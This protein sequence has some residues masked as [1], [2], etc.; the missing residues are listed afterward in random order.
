MLI[1]DYYRSEPDQTW[2]IGR[3][4]GIRHGVIRLPEDPEFDPADRSHWLTVDRRF[5]EY[6]IQPIVVEP[7]PNCLHDHIKAGD[8]RRDE[9]I[10]K[11]IRMFSIM[12]ELEIRTI[13]FNW[14]TYVG[15]L[16]TRTDIQE[17]GGALV[18]GFDFREMLEPEKQI[19]ANQLW[20]NY[21]Y[22]LRAVIPEAERHGIRLALHPDDPPLADLRGVERIM[23]SYEN[24][25]RAIYEIVP[26]PSLG[27]TFCQASFYLM[28][29]NL[30][31]IIPKLAGK[32]MYIH[33]RNVKG[34]KEH[35]QE[36]FHDNGDLD[37]PALLRLYHRC[38]ID[39]PIRVDHVPT[40]LGE[41]QQNAGYDALG[42]LYAIG[43]LRG[44][45]ETIE[46]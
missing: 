29:Q 42:R 5:R 30:F 10:E 22:F 43:Y 9:S 17:R 18:T 26:S 35:F 4:L 34:T 6:G 31:E 28:G 46:K 12:E 1:T 8:A 19:S 24:I 39:V 45:L 44:I 21:T 27:V 25:R 41:T 33:F 2:E 32:I 16:R 36:T 11:V 40:M 7:M 23:V 37:M 13:C 3:Q 38:G 20:D 14:M 15:W